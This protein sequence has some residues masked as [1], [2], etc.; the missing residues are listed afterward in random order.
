MDEES[1][2]AKILRLEEEGRLIDLAQFLQGQNFLVEE[3]RRLLQQL[4]AQ[5][6]IKAA[7]LL[8]MMLQRSGELGLATAL[9]LSV[10]GIAFAKE[11]EAGIGLRLLQ[12]AIDNGTLQKSDLFFREQLF[13]LLHTVLQKSGQRLAADNKTKIINILACMANSSS[14][15]SGWQ[16]IQRE[17]VQAMELAEGEEE[18]VS[19]LLQKVVALEGMGQGKEAALTQLFVAQS[20]AIGEMLSLLRDLMRRKPPL[21][22]AAFLLARLLDHVEERHWLISVALSIGGLWRGMRREY[23]RGLLQLQELSPSLS[24]QQRNEIYTMVIAPLMVALLQAKE[25]EADKELHR[26]MLEIGKA[27]V[28]MLGEV[29][30]QEGEVARL[31]RES[32]RSLAA[33]RGGARL[34][35]ALPV[36]PQQARRVVLFMIDSYIVYRLE[37]AMQAYGWQ[38]TVRLLSEQSD[39]GWLLS[40]LYEAIALCQQVRAELFVIRFDQIMQGR[41]VAHDL[42]LL[43]R[44]RLPDVKIVALSLDAWTINQNLPG[45]VLPLQFHEK[46]YGILEVLDAVWLSDVPLLG[47][48]EEVPFRGKVLRT[49]LPHGEYFGP[50]DPPLARVLRY[51]GNRLHPEF[52][53]RNFWPLVTEEKNLPIIYQQ[54]RFLDAQ[55][56]FDQGRCQLTRGE[57]ALRTYSGHKRG[58]HEATV[59]MN[60]TRKANL[61]CIVTHRSFEVPLNGGLLVQEYTP[62]MHCYFTPGEHYLEFGS[63]GGLGEICRLLVEEPEWAEEIRRCGSAFA[64]AHYNDEKLIAYLDCFLWP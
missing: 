64:R 24:Y 3:L 30:A 38:V 15:L 42:L 40:E 19:G 43:M 55:G 36:R 62:E 57:E 17:S 29:F 58:L 33:E 47:I 54:H 8:A 26:A 28:P 45:D 53:Y 46:V 10:G 4:L 12:E 32:L 35:F 27:V 11:Q 23:Q 6:R 39:G 59:V 37:T 51:F 7:Y 9:A 49:P 20:Y 41:Q 31:T 48:W 5:R 22:E 16:R 52:W 61:Q 63:V 13:P 60:M 25:A 1:V 21:L 44:E 18:E 56:Y 50:P 2:L 34:S 14:L